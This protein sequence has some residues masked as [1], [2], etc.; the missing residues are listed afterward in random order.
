MEYGDKP[1]WST[2]ITAV[3]Y[4]LRRPDLVEWVRCMVEYCESMRYPMKYIVG[5]FM[6]SD[7]FGFGLET[8]P[9]FLDGQFF[10]S[11]Q[12]ALMRRYLRPGMALIMD[13]TI[14]RAYFIAEVVEVGEVVVVR[15]DIDDETLGLVPGLYISADV[16]CRPWEPSRWF[17]VCPHDDRFAQ[18][19]EEEAH[20]EIW[21]DNVALIM[22][23]PV[24]RRAARV[25]I[26][27]LK[28]A[29][30]RSRAARRI[31]KAML[32]W[33]DQ[34]RCRDGRMGIRLRVA[35]KNSLE[36]GLVKYV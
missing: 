8:D 29:V 35:L 6:D 13:S 21:C 25:I 28:L 17:A 36:E 18:Y 31:Q 5:G 19:I 14:D 32:P 22:A 11:M 33:L 34:P 15:I 1:G 9:V 10:D 16:L 27:A 23:V 7:H 3:F 20:I 24:L 30:R 26:R 4:E 12:H 2:D